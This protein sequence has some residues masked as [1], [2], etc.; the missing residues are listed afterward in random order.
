[1]TIDILFIWD[2]GDTDRWANT[3]ANALGDVRF[4]VFP[5]VPDKSAIDYVLAWMPPIGELKTYPNLKAIFSIGAGASHI[6]RDPYLPGGVPIVRLV[7]DVSVE[8]MW[9][10]ACYWVL[11]YHRHFDIYCLQQ[12]EG[13]WHRRPV[14]TPAQRRVCVLGLG[15]I[16]GRIAKGL[17]DMGF[18]TAGWSRTAKNLDGVECFHGPD[19]LEAILGRSEI[20]VNLL[21]ATAET[22]NLLDA[23]CLSLLPKGAVLINLGRGEVLDDAALLVALD[24]G[25]MGGATLDVFRIE[26]LPSDHPFWTHPSVAITPHAAGP[27]N[28]DSAPRQIA[29]DIL[30]LERGEM[31]AHLVNVKQG[32]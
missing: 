10:Y 5:D 14:L 30:K 26:P 23:R 9:H 20:V 24:A 1:M 32:Y 4:H 16:G 12:G 21:P 29:A 28:Q 7:D 19:G 15:A 6:L 18:E 2:G 25:A 27:T 13:T 11:H 22:T 17:A 31:P 3:L 8:D